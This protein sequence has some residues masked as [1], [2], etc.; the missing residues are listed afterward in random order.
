MPFDTPLAW[1]STI[2][3]R[4]VDTVRSLKVICIGAGISGILA[5]I[6]L[7][8]VVRTLDLVIHDKNEELGGTSFENKYAGCSCG[9]YYCYHVY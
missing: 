9:E 5:A 2:S 3:D 6:N 1:E 8:Q 7:P 4:S